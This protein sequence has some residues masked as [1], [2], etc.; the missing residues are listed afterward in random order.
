M[1]YRKNYF[2][3]K[4]DEFLASIYDECFEDTTR[5]YK[6]ISDRIHTSD[7]LS[8]VDL[9]AVNQIQHAFKTF[10]NQFAADSSGDIRQIYE[11]IRKRLARDVRRQVR[12][13]RYIEYDAWQEQMGL[14]KEQFHI[15]LGTVC[16]LQLTVGCS[17]FCRRCNEWALPGPR[18]H[19]TFEAA[20]K[21]IKELFEAGNSEFVLYCASDPLDWKCGEK[22]VVDILSFMKEHG[23][24]AQYGLLTKIPRGSE[25]N[26]EALFKM[27]ADIGFS[28][29]DKNR[30]KVEKLQGT[31]GKKLDLQHDFD[32]LLIPSGLDEDFTTIKSSITDNYGTEITPEG[33]FL[34]IPTF[35]SPLNLTGQRRIPITADMNF[36]LKKRVGRDALPVE[37]FKPLKAVD[38]KGQEFTLDGLFEAQIE[39]ILLDNDSEQLTPPGMIGLHEYFK[40]YEPDAVERRKSLLPAVEKR[41]RKEI[42]HQEKYKGN[43]RQRRDDH[44]KQ[45]VEDYFMSCQMEH[46]MEYKKNAFSYYMKCISD[47]LKT[48]PVEREIILFLRKKDWEKYKNIYPAMFEEH[49]HNV[50]DILEKAEIDAFDIFQILMSRLMNDPDNKS[51]QT[52][53]ENYPVESTASFL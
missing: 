15:M 32:T 40:T 47:Y 39:N 8:E 10:R 35:T 46:V 6:E 23:Y 19:F 30:F 45:Q 2:D 50:P 27:D 18:K 5:I 38:L 16:T 44:F 21:F 33:A 36:F 17:V 25:K 7:T 11:R 53:I 3:K 37:Y 9:K 29:T 31:A 51:I 42:V 41:L 13:V 12:D 52:F 26:I 14:A 48:H 49:D 20:K 24:N 4:R 28:V 34:V 1:N 43:S 22:N